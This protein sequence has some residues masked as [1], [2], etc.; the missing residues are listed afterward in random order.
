VRN[1]QGYANDLPADHLYI[2]AEKTLKR[3]LRFKA[4]YQKMI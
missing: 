3:L 2:L 1:A 4:F